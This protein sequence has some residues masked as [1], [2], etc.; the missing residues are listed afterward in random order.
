MT[1]LEYRV[2]CQLDERV[3]VGLPV[4]VNWGYGLGF[5]ATGKGRIVK[6]YQKSVRIQLDEDV[7]LRPGEVG[8]HKGFTLQG[9]PRPS[10]WE[11]WHEANCFE[12]LT[13]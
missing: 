4:Q 7:T 2:L 5:R 10:N 11:H 13:A 3:A 6:V 1:H 9:I 8:W 12:P